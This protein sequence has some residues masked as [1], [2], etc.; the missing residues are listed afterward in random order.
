MIPLNAK[1]QAE[2]EHA[3]RKAIYEFLQNY[4]KPASLGEIGE[5]IDQ[6]DL[7]IAFY[8]LNRLVEVELVEKVLGTERYRAVEP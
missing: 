1:Q 2:L 7:A 6:P 4:D 5:G 3:T 8:H